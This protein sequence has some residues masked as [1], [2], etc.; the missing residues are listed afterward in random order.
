MKQ[1]SLV[2]TEIERLKYKY[3]RTI[4]QNESGND[5]FD[6]YLSKDHFIIYIYSINKLEIL[7]NQIFKN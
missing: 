6:L 7:E 4:P 2:N 1:F 5:F 3:V